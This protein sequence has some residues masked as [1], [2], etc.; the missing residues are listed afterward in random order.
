MNLVCAWINGQGERKGLLYCSA[1][2]M[3]AS[4]ISRKFGIWNLVKKITESRDIEGEYI[5]DE[6]VSR[7]YLENIKGKR[8]RNMHLSLGDSATRRAAVL[9]QVVFRTR[10]NS[11]IGSRG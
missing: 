4:G 8:T 3:R 9:V 1:W 5:R 7:R 10:E 6:S 2:E 11:S